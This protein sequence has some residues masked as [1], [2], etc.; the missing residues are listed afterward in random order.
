MT[1]T[2]YRVTLALLAIALI[3]VIG[4]SI[5][6]IPAG[7]PEQLPQ[8]VERYSPHD[9]DIVINPVTVMI[10]LKPNYTAEFII[11]GTPIPADEMNSIVETGRHEFVPGP[12]KTI[13]RWTPGDHTVVATWL[14]GA[15]SIDAGTLLWTFQIQ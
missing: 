9:G 14:G 4:G 7:D 2:G 15:N 10:D 12:G 5:L 13:E 3:A 1:T 8:A 6:L 11:D